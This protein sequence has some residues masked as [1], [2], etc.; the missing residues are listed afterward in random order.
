MDNK[1]QIRLSP[2]NQLGIPEFI[3]RKQR[4]SFQAFVVSRVP[5][6]GSDTC[7]PRVFAPKLH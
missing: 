5:K 7:F 2:G 4:F 1:I 6:L 3:N